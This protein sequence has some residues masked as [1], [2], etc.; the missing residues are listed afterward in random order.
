[1][2]ELLH[3]VITSL[4]LSAATGGGVDA[5]VT[6]D[7]E[8]ANSETGVDVGKMPAHLVSPRGLTQS[9]QGDD[10]QPTSLAEHA[11]FCEPTVWI[12]KPFASI[13]QLPQAAAF[14][15]AGRSP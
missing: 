9:E 1:M 14:Q 3:A 15:T 5:S 6:T 4:L 13:Q 7:D 12:E 2:L 11:S 8:P 10:H